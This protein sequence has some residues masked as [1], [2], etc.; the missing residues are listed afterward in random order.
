MDE[1]TRAWYCYREECI[2]RDQLIARAH[3]T[4]PQAAKDHDLAL[5][6]LLLGR[7]SYRVNERDRL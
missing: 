2:R 3:Q 4:A 7:G 6:E 5:P 1:A